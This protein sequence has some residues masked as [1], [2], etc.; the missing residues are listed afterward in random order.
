MF[1]I[2]ETDRLVLRELKEDDA[3]DILSCFSNKEVLRYYGQKPL[4]SID[5]VQQIIRNFSMN[6]NEKRGIKWGIELKGRE[7]IVGT[8]GFQEWTQEHQRADLSYALYPDNWGNG[9]ASEAVCKVVSYGFE[10][11][12]IKRIGAVVFTENKASIKLLTKLGFQKEGLLRN[13]LYQNGVPFDAYIYSL[14]K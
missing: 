8:I 9:Y 5:Q 1:P 14:L 3:I 6:F 4:T 13:Y 7:G 12:A 10:E 11:L 2:L